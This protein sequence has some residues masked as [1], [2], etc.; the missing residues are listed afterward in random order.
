MSFFPHHSLLVTE[1]TMKRIIFIAMLALVLAPGSVL[2]QLAK[3]TLKQVIGVTGSTSRTVQEVWLPRGTYVLAFKGNP[4]GVQGHAI[5]TIDRGD[6]IAWLLDDFDD[7]DGD[8][9]WEVFEIRRGKKAK[10][11]VI[12]GR[13]AVYH[14]QVQLAWGD[15]KLDAILAD[16]DQETGTTKD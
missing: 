2:A 10:V 8:K 4:G 9:E 1:N 12:D 13:G 3:A 11:V 6:A 7:L 14:V 5:V 16:P 15:R